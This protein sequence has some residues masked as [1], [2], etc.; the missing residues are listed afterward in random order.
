MHPHFDERK[1]NIITQLRDLRNVI[2]N[3]GG[4]QIAFRPL[5]EGNKLLTRSR[6]EKPTNLDIQ[7][8]VDK[9]MCTYEHH[10]CLFQASQYT[11]TVIEDARNKH[12]W[13]YNHWDNTFRQKRQ[14][15]QCVGFFLYINGRAYVVR[16]MPVVALTESSPHDSPKLYPRW[17]ILYLVA[18]EVQLDSIEDRIGEKLRPSSDSYSE[19]LEW[20]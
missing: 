18:T 11:G 2:V 19:I 14:L 12:N 15:S 4:G 5:A 16:M 10:I 17:W 3:R 7:S 8:R 9:S 13:V 20:C 6:G 1:L